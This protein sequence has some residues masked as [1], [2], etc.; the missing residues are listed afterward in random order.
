MGAD[1]DRPLRGQRPRA[2]TAPCSRWSTTGWSRRRCS[3]SPDGRAADG[4]GEFAR[5]GGMARGRPALAT[6]L[7]TTGVI[8]LAVPRLVGVRGRVPDPRRRLPVGLGL[9]GR[10]RGR[11]RA[12]GDVHAAA[13]LR[14]APPR[15]RARPSRDAALDLRPAELGVVVPLVALPARPL[16]VARGDHRALVRRARRHRSDRRCPRL[17][18]VI[19]DAAQ[20]TGSRSRRR[21]R[22]SRAGGVCAARSRCSCR[23]RRASRSRPRLRAGFVGRVRRSRSL[24]VDGTPPRRRRRSSDAIARDR[25]AA[26]A[27]SSS[28]AAGCSPCCVSYGERWRE[29][30]RRRVLRA[31]RRGRRRDGLLRRRTNLMTLFLGLEWFSI[32]L[33]ILCAIDIDLARLARGRAEVPDRRR[34]RLGGAAVRLA[35]SSTARP[36]SSTSTRSRARGA[37]DDAL[38]ARRPRDGDRRARASRPRRRRSTC[39][40]RTST[41][42]RRRR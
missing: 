20:S 32:C 38:L 34:V 40:R 41:R 13:D 7:M 15:R 8:A 35:R 17:R 6:V 10:R 25:S 18:H 42:A 9:V 1:H 19:D 29:R 31:A 4:T 3:C 21:W 36:A 11:D 24:L 33:Y 2:S 28:P 14:R 30:P 16:G 23:A 39:G 12:R 27:R 22:C 5:L 37:S 26:L